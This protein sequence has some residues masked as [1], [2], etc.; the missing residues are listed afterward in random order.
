MSFVSY[1]E[2]YRFSTVGPKRSLKTNIS[3]KVYLPGDKMF[4]PTFCRL[5]G[6]VKPHLKIIYKDPQDVLAIPLEVIRAFLQDLRA[7]C[8]NNEVLIRKALSQM[9]QNFDLI[10]YRIFE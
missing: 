10:F 8:K 6:C 7:C 1:C 9:T 2:S 5:T 3:N 4:W